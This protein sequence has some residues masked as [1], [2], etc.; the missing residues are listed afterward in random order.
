MLQGGRRERADRTGA[1]RALSTSVTGVG[2]S[3]LASVSQSSEPPSALSAAVRTPSP[4]THWHQRPTPC[5]SGG[6][7]PTLQAMNVASSWAPSRDPLSSGSRQ[8]AGASPS[9]R[10]VICPAPGIQRERR[11]QRSGPGGTQLCFGPGAYL[12]AA[13]GPLC[14]RAAASELGSTGPRGRPRKGVSLTL[15]LCLPEADRQVAEA[16]SLVHTLDRWSVVERM[17]VPARTPD[18]K[19]AFGRGTLRH[20]TGGPCSLA[21]FLLEQER[22]GSRRLGRVEASSRELGSDVQNASVPRSQPELCPVGPS[23]QFRVRWKPAPGPQPSPPRRQG[24]VCEPCLPGTPWGVTLQSGEPCGYAEGVLTARLCHRR[25]WSHSDPVGSCHLRVQDPRPPKGPR[26]SPPLP[27][28]P[29]FPNTH[30]GSRGVPG[31]HSQPEPRVG[32]TTDPMEP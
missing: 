23:G 14:R 19:V 24:A 2:P 17:V 31:D 26:S 27:H 6:S 13:S 1:Q 11:L 9:P 7:Q 22:W 25:S 10:P 5:L 16:E 4:R 30:S 21:L 20:L 28:T 32:P 29:D 8:T 3:T 15:A 12:G 18:G